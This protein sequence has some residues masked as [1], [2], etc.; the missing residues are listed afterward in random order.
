M[1]CPKKSMMAG[2]TCVAPY[3]APEW[4][5][6]RIS[7]SPS[8]PYPPEIARRVD[9]ASNAAALCPVAINAYQILRCRGDSTGRIT[10]GLMGAIKNGS[11]PGPI[12][13]ADEEEEEA[14]AS[15]PPVILGA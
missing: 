10:A 9:H 15:V 8:V 4:A 12:P 2:L 14:S 6:G 11:L 13:S 3:I 5:N 1:R 7:G